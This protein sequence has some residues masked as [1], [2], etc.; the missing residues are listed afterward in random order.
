[1]HTRTLGQG[2]EV[3]AIGIGAMGMSQSFGPNP[4]D[5]DDMIGVLR[6][7]VEHG[8]TLIDT[9]EVYGPFDNEE[10]VGQALA[11]ADGRRVRVGTGARNLPALALYERFGF[12][13]RAGSPAADRSAGGVAAPAGAA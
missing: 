5:R 11:R 3:S 12:R 7:A 1:M 6:Y 10:L 2:L 4:G 9:A 8:V 13:R